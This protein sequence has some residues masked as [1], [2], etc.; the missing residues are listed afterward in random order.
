MVPAL[1]V[2][3]QDSLIQI[4]TK[5]TK[6]NSQSQVQSANLITVNFSFRPKDVLSRFEYQFD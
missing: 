3:F 5:L 6:T 1:D 2:I 4:H